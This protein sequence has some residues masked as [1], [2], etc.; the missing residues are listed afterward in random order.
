MLT[1]HTLLYGDKYTYDDVNRIAAC[2]GEDYRVV[3]HTDQSEKLR[4]EGL[5]EDIILRWA[6]VKL[7]TFNKVNILGEDWGESLYLDLDVVIQRPENLYQFFSNDLTI[8]KTYWKPDGFEAEHGGGDFN[9]SVIAWKGIAG[10]H[11]TKHF[12]KDPKKY[13]KKY[14][15]CDDKYLF[16]EHK[17]EFGVFEKGKIYSFIFGYDHTEEDS[18]KIKR[19]DEYDIAL[20]NGAAD[21]GR[22]LKAEY[23]ATFSN[24]YVGKEIYT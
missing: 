23:Y 3:C 1:I 19:R 15:G 24:N 4:K 20:L 21:L 16:H 5:Y 2:V 12:N 14:K 17:K 11:I 8:C 13:L 18:K 6:D 7:G 22:D 10:N 9:S